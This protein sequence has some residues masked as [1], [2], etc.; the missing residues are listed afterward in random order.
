M[1]VVIEFRKLCLNSKCFAKTSQG[2][3][4]FKSECFFFY[5]ESSPLR[6]SR[7]KTRLFM[8]ESSTVLSHSHSR[9]IVLT[10]TVDVF[11]PIPLWVASLPEY[12]LEVH[13]KRKSKHS[14]KIKHT[15][16]SWC[17]WLWYNVT[18]CFCILAFTTLMDCNM[19]LKH[20]IT[21]SLLGCSLLEYFKTVAEWK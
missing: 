5:S 15:F 6:P 7:L 3:I 10:A 4:I 18:S 1:W 17:F 14:P 12:G 11:I 9:R 20:K 19:T 21:F 13:K 2:W 8:Q 16:T